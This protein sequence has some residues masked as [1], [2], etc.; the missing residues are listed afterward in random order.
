MPG[1]F[2][3]AVRSPALSRLAPHHWCRNAVGTGQP[4]QALPLSPPPEWEL[5]FSPEKFCSTNVFALLEVGFSSELGSGLGCQHLP[6]LLQPG[7]VHP[8]PAQPA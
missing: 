6:H 4:C 7:R 5:K 8:Q 2:V 3:P 1:G